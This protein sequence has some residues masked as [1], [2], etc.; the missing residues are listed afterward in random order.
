[1]NEINPIKHLTDVM[2]TIFAYH[3]KGY[4]LGVRVHEHINTDEPGISI[5]LYHFEGDGLPV[6][7]GLT[8]KNEGMEELQRAYC[9]SYN[10]G[11]K[12]EPLRVLCCDNEE[13]KDDYDV[14]P[15]D[16]P[17]TVLIAITQWLEIEMVKGQWFDKT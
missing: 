6:C 11:W 13:V 5:D 15:E 3:Y 1:M 8:F 2:Q 12:D 9:I 17:N 10:P 16:L 4:G 14:L 7:E